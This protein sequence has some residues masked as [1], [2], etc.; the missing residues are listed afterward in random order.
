MRYALTDVATSVDHQRRVNARTWLAGYGAVLVLCAVV[1]ALGV[2]SA[3]QPL[4]LPLTMLLLAAGAVALKPVFG[5]YLI[6]FFVLFSD[7]SISPWFPFAKNLSSRESVLYLSDGLTISPLEV[8][9]GVTAASWLLHLLIDRREVTLVRARLFKP[10]LVFT[11]FVF[12][13]IAYGT[14]MG[15]NRWFAVWEFRPLLYL[16]IMYILV[17]NLFTT[18]RQY[19]RLFLVMLVAL[20]AHAVLALDKYLQLSAA[21]RE[22]LESL[23][24]HG[25]AVQFGM[26][27]LAVLAAWMLPKSPTWMRVVLPV[28]A[29]PVA[30]TWVVSERRAAAIGLAVGLIL[31]AAVLALVK[32]KRLLVIAPVLLLLIVGYLGAFWQSEDPIG[33]PAQA[34]K[35]VIAPGDTSSQDQ[36]SNVYRAIEN[37]DIMFTIKSKPLTGLGF[38]HAFYKPIPLPDISFFVFYQYIPHNSILWIWIKLGIGG[39]LAML[40]LFGSALRAGV[41]SIMQ[42]RPG[43]DLLMTVLAAGYIVMY[44]VFAYVDIAWDPR[45]MICVAVAMAICSSYAGLPDDETRAGHTADPLEQ[46][47]DRLALDGQPASVQTRQPVLAST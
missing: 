24:D 14:V 34:I 47:S 17:T 22:G 6:G 43:R 1:G 37:Y 20:L 41:R 13:G 8:L 23:V 16:P 2:R 29:V 5:I 26:I 10:M 7:A 32:P 39:F 46:D 11:G 45:S 35:S 3:P 38:G 27:L 36:S 40:Y 12:F 21:E 19:V 9:L 28:L 33:F 44:L 15:G 4:A 31:V 25:S 18:R 30:W 42:A